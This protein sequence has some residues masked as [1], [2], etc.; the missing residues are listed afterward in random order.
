MNGEDVRLAELKSLFF[1]D[2]GKHRRERVIGVATLPDGHGEERVPF[3]DPCV[4]DQTGRRINRW[5]TTP[6][7]F[8]L[9]GGHGW[10][11]VDNGDRHTVFYVCSS[12]N[13]K[14]FRQVQA[15]SG[16]TINDFNVEQV[17]SSCAEDKGRGLPLPTFL[18]SPWGR[19]VTF[20]GRNQPY[21]TECSAALS[22]RGR[23]ATPIALASK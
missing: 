14:N 7:L 17:S 22:Q 3:S 19:H 2:P 15:A 8:V 18:A 12:G 4:E 16:T 9:V 21:L 13:G 23:R 20:N 1:H 11:S 6:A 10:R 5:T